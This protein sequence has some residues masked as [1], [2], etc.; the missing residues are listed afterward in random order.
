MRQPLYRWIGPFTHGLKPFLWPIHLVADDNAPHSYGCTA[1]TVSPINLGTTPPPALQPFSAPLQKVTILAQLWSQPFGQKFC[2]I[3]TTKVLYSSF[4]S[5]LNT[6]TVHMWHVTVSG[7]SHILSFQLSIRGNYLH[8]TPMIGDKSV[9]TMNRESSLQI[10]ANTWESRLQIHG[11]V[12]GKR[13]KSFAEAGTRQPNMR[14][15]INQVQIA[16]GTNQV[17][18]AAFLQRDIFI[19]T[20]EYP[21]IFIPTQFSWVSGRSGCKVDFPQEIWRR[22]MCLSCF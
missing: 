11:P 15:S 5:F 18:I 21:Q 22:D 17:Q 3:F 7:L 10:H 4:S 9:R 14:A 6:V 2:K 12:G 13:E 16:P 8:W 1:H 19:I 20:K